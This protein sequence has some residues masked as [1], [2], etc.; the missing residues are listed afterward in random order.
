MTCGRDVFHDRA[1]C[2]VTSEI[3]AFS[4]QIAALLDCGNGVCTDATTCVPN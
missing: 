3:L 2:T 4:P 1:D